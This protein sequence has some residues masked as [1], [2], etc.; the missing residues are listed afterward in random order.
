[1]IGSPPNVAVPT[2]FAKVVLATKPSSTRTSDILEFSTGAF[3]LPNSAIPDEAPLESFV[4]PGFSTLSHCLNNESF[5][6]F[7]FMTVEAVERAAG[8]IL[9][10]DDVKA[11]SKHICKTA[12]CEVIVRRFDDVQ[13]TS[14]KALS[15]PRR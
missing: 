11:T 4:M 1:M 8:L 10:S 12:K 7:F 6:V 5:L 9:F 15:V 14:Q 3:V 13:K 2:H